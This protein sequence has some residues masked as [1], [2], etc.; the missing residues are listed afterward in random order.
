M[1]C[2]WLIAALVLAAGA[3]DAFV[4][5]PLPLLVRHTSFWHWN[6]R[7]ARASSPM[8]QSLSLASA[9]QSCRQARY[10]HTCIFA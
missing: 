1:T 3:A 4:T 8:L 9:H 5:A 10:V 2:I 6:P 7:C